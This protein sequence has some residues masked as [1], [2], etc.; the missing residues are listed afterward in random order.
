MT[1][2]LFFRPLTVTG[3]RVTAIICNSDQMIGVSDPDHA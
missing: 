2:S 1:G 3:V